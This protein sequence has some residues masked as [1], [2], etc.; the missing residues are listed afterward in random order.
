MIREEMIKESSRIFTGCSCLYV[1]NAF[2]LL[3]AGR[4]TAA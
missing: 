4:F 2:R 1:I 3:L